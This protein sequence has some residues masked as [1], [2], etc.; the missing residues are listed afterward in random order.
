[1]KNKISKLLKEKNGSTYIDIV[2][3]FLIGCI[4]IA[5]I[6]QVV[7][8]LV[9]KN[10]LNTFATNV[11]RI[12]SVEGIYND[13]VKRKIEE[14]RKSSE[15]GN[16]T[17]SLDGTE[18]I[19]NTNKIQLSDPI[20]VTVTSDYDIALFSFGGFTIPIKNKAETRSEVYWK[21]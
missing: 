17:V 7:P 11:S 10:Q 5:L 14:Y 12:I 1:M 2:V 3:G 16:V 9:K 19:E 8:A 20:E 15:V 18:F 21:E 13:D 4:V 6:I